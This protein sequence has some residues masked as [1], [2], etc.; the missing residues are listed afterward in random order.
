MS[1]IIEKRNEYIQSQ[2]AKLEQ[3]ASGVESGEILAN[4]D[5]KQAV[6]QYRNSFNRGDI[7]FRHDEIYEKGIALYFQKKRENYAVSIACSV[8]HC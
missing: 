2:I 1:D 8:C 7:E 5:I 6:K 3:Y 4:K